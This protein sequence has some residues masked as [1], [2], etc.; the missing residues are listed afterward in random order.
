[1]SIRSAATAW[2][3]LFRAQ[4]TLMQKFEDAK[5]FAPLRSRE[6]DVLFNLAQLGGRARQWELNERLLIS[7]PSL[8]RML[9]RLQDAG[10]VRREASPSDG[11][12][13]IVVLTDEGARLQ[14]QIGRRHVRHIAALVDAALTEQEQ[15]ELAALATKLRD[16]AMRAAAGN[17][18]GRRNSD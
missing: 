15:E 16:G 14:T 7:Q 6:Y 9:V 10:Y 5:D 3:A 13:V 12:E 1:M 8:S 4:V 11:R 18:P 17:R 2:E